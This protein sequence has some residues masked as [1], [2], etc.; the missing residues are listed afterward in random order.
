MSGGHGW[1]DEW[2]EAE[3][4]RFE[5]LLSHLVCGRVAL[6]WCHIYGPRITCYRRQL[7]VRGQLGRKWNVV[8]PKACKMHVKERDGIRFR[9][10]DPSTFCSHCV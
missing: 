8:A 10:I 1:D 9:R 5:H 7:G 6:G 3:E 2:G 4:N